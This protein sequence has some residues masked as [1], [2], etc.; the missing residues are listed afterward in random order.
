MYHGKRVK[1]NRKAGA[2]LAS[3][4]L[5]LGVSVVGAVAFLVD[6]SDPVVNTFTPA[7]VPPEIVEEFNGN[8]KKDVRV[9]NNGNIDAYIR[10]AVVVNWVKKDTNEKDTNEIDGSVPA[11]E[12]GTDY[13]LT[14][15]GITDKTWEKGDDGYYYYV[16]SV[17]P[18]GKTSVLFTNCKPVDGK[19]TAERTLSVEI[20]AESIQA[21]PEQAVKDAWGT[22]FSI[23]SD[24]TLKVPTNG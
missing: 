24:G 14:W 9:Q 22:G 3:L 2:L 10:A 18:G 5:I 19:V 11:P 7:K 17:K 6:S 15:S 12:E 21:V 4:V 8:V 20:I 16:Q 1:R 13:T 23:N